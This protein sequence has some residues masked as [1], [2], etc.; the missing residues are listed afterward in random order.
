MTND[1]HNNEVVL[2]LLRTELRM[3]EDRME[4]DRHRLIRLK[5]WV[6]QAER[7]NG[8]FDPISVVLIEINRQKLDKA[9]ILALFDGSRSNRDRFLR[10]KQ[11]LNLPAIRRLHTHLGIPYEILVQPYEVEDDQAD[12]VLDAV[13]R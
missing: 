1:R 8:V 10:R 6:D 12:G 5:V 4:I 11:R 7:A 13:T 3:L 9:A 2:S